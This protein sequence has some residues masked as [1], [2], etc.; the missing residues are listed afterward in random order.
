[1]VADCAFCS[2]FSCALVISLEAALP[3]VRF[4]DLNWPI[5]HNPE[6]YQRLIDLWWMFALSVA[7]FIGTVYFVWKRH[8]YWLA[9]WL[10]IGQFSLAFLAYGISHY[11]YLLYPHLSIYDSFTNVH[12]FRLQQEKGCFRAGILNQ[13]WPMD[14]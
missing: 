3:V 14:M 11:P 1:M 7:F 9:F 12:R 4:M 10:L 6:H 8:S 2:F 5:F 13:C